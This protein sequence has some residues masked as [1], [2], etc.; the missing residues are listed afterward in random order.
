MDATGR[1]EEVTLDGLIVEAMLAVQRRELLAATSALARAR[2]MADE[3]ACE[4]HHL[5]LELAAQL[6]RATGS[7]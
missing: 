2:D 7:A 6:G 1:D 5:R 3:L 4:V